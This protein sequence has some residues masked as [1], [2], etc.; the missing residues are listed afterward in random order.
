M[1][2]G[3]GTNKATQLNNSNTLERKQSSYFLITLDEKKK[4]NRKQRETYRLLMENSTEGIISMGK[5]FY[6]WKQIEKS[7]RST[8]RTLYSIEKN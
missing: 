5:L 3:K 6:Y 1:C 2:C 7:A 8:K 4:E